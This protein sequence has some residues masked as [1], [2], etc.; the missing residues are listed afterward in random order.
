MDAV[1]TVLPGDT[2]T[3]AAASPGD[4]PDGAHFTV[5]VA[6]PTTA[7]ASHAE[8]ALYDWTEADAVLPAGATSA[9]LVRPTAADAVALADWLPVGSLLGFEVVDPGPAGAAGAVGAPSARLAARTGT[10]DQIRMPLASHPAQVV[11]VTHAV[12][13]SDPLAPG[14]PLVRVFWDADRRADRAVPV[15]IDTSGGS[16]RVGVARLG[17]RRRA[18]RP[19]R[20]RPGRGDAVRPAH[21]LG[22]RS[23]DD[24]CHRLLAVR[25]RGGRAVLLAGRRTVAARHQHRAA[26]RRERRGAAGDQPA[27]C[28]E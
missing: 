10:G 12:A 9:V 8:I 11:R 26:E 14:L 16:P 24:D 22:S 21:Q 25:R 6:G 5:E 2:A 18:P 7:R 28:A 19:V 4:A 23:G 15:S 3:D 27:A 1:F 20:R 13:I 17:A